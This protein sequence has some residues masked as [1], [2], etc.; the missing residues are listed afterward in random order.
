MKHL[1]AEDLTENQSK[2]FQ[3]N[4]ALPWKD[5]IIDKHLQGMSTSQIHKK[6][7]SEF[8][9]ASD[10]AIGSVRNIIN[11]LNGKKKSAKK[12]DKISTNEKNTNKSEAIR[13]LAKEMISNG[14]ELNYTNI[15]KTLSNRGI[16]V[17]YTHVA[18][19]IGQSVLSKRLSLGSAQS[20]E[21][22]LK[23]NVPCS[24]DEIV[25]AKE[26]VEKLGGLEK[27]IS[28]ISA[29]NRLSTNKI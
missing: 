19:A 8:P 2:Y 18:M 10:V 28:A 17:S 7:I 13:L 24:F 16:D 20:S 3:P 11:K 26:F 15:V 27:A 21:T 25:N 23:Q 12:I 6:L 14:I 4:K 22:A 9:A 29:Y 5:W 1:T